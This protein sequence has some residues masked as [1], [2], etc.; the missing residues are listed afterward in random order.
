MRGYSID[1]T[2]L[3]AVEVRITRNNVFPE[4]EVAAVAADNTE[5]ADD[6]KSDEFPLDHAPSNHDDAGGATVPSVEPQPGRRQGAVPDNRLPP[7]QANKFEFN[8][9]PLPDKPLSPEEKNR[10][11]Y[12]IN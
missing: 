4:E 8:E 3:M 11:H 2:N 7:G 10:R 6:E 9:I 5:E 1:E 12:K